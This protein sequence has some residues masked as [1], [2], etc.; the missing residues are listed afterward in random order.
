MRFT[1]V[2]PRGRVSF[3]AP[4]STLEALVAACASQ[5]QPRTLEQLLK[6]AEPFVGDLA[7]RV[8][9]GLAVF[10]EHNSPTN[11]RW[12]HAALDYCA[13]HEIP[14]FRVVD[15]RTE[16]VSLSPVR[17]GVVVFNLVAKRIVQLQNTYSEIRRK[18]RVRVVRNN[19]PTDR[20]YRYELP[21]D[22]SL[23]PSRSA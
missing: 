18:G 5:H 13:A 7:D 6:A 16:E 4:C 21:P 1:V 8:L 12:V 3:V 23:V 9:S 19:Q 2:D 11:Y 22:W 14:A 10:D 17:A 20:V 15:P